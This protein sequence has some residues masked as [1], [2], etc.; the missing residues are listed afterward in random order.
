MFLACS[1]VDYLCR[2]NLEFK[3]LRLKLYMISFMVHVDFHSFVVYYFYYTF[4]SKI[5]SYNVPKYIIIW[6]KG[7]IFILLLRYENIYKKR[8]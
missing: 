1:C 4:S 6:I 2:F 3:S 8:N 7:Y 5:G